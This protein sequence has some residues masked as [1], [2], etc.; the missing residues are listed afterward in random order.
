MTRASAT[1]PWRDYLDR[2]V[3]EMK[4]SEKQSFLETLGVTRSTL[5]RWR[6]GANV[7]NAEHMACLL[8]GLAPQVREQFGELLKED[9][10]MR[11]RLSPEAA[12]AKKMG[13]SDTFTAEVFRLQRDASDRFWLLC[14]AILR[15]ALGQL[16]DYPR[17]PVGME[18]VVARCMPPQRDGKIR[19]LRMVVGMGTPPWRQDLHSQD[20]FLGSESVAG[21]AILRRRGEMVPDTAEKTLAS[22][23]MRECE[24]SCAAFPILFGN[25]I[26]GAICVVCTQ[27]HYFTSEH[28]EL[29][30]QYADLMRLAFYDTDF[31]PASS[32]DLQQMPPRIIQ[33]AKLETFRQRI[34][35]EYR[36]AIKA[37]GAFRN[38]AQIEQRVRSL[39]EEELLHMVDK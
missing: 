31:Y 12:L 23:Y 37:D 34:A 5:Q 20:T 33:L 6:N 38:I 30:E 1:V 36:K 8:G 25:R 32:I 19:S 29:I 16:E 27:P 7:P 9:P 4:A 15:H 35:A 24:R 13:I 2:L 18:I 28:L 17:Q 39:L 26:A 22:L 3:R 11:L 10:H 14:S 21:W